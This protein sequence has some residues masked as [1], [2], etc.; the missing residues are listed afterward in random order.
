VR[1]PSRVQH[2]LPENQV[3]VLPLADADPGVLPG[4]ARAAPSLSASA[5]GSRR[6][7]LPRRLARAG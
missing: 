7:A 6:R 4:A 1:M 5:A 2:A 3:H